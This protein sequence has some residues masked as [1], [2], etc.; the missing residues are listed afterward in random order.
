MAKNKSVR[1]SFKILDHTLGWFKHWNSCLAMIM[2]ATRILL[3][4]SRLQLL[5]LI[6]LRKTIIELLSCHF[7]S[8]CICSF[9]Q[10]LRNVL[11]YSC[12][13]QL[14]IKQLFHIQVSE[15]WRPQS[16]FFKQS[17][18]PTYPKFTEH[19]PIILSKNAR[20]ILKP[21]PATRLWMVFW[22]QYPLR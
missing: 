8:T 14:F 2:N 5:P 20:A 11:C 9:S 3:N 13:K 15:I 12:L 16:I 18:C 19:F 1:P 6:D 7:F 10:Q 17:N 22:V 21:G 4:I